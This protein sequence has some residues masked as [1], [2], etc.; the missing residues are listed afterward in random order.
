[1][2]NEEKHETYVTDLAGP[3]D[4]WLSVTDAARIT[5]RQEKTIRDWIE[6]GHLPVH[7][8]RVGLNKRTR[9]VRISDLETLTPIIDPEA[10]ITTDLGLLDLPNIPRAQQHLAEQM[11]TLQQDVG[12]QITA[13]REQ[14]G[15]LTSQHEQFTTDT[16]QVWGVHQDQYRALDHRDAELLRLIQQARQDW[17]AHLQEV[18]RTLGQD[19]ARVLDLHQH[20]DSRVAAQVQDL[21]QAHQDLADLVAQSETRLHQEVTTLASRLAEVEQALRKERVDA[22]RDLERMLT[23]QDARLAREAAS[24]RASLSDLDTRTATAFQAAQEAHQQEHT[25]L[26]ERSLD[27]HRELRQLQETT[28]AQHAD[29]S[30]RLTQLTGTTAAMHTTWQQRAETAE[31]EVRQL[32]RDL[33]SPTPSPPASPK[34]SPKRALFHDHSIRSAKVM[35]SSS[36]PSSAPSSPKTSPKASPTTSPKSS[37][38][39]SP[40]L[41]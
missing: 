26:T 12:E 39:T 32:R 9:Q 13:L 25:V 18:S 14:L 7:P 38:K 22:V 29:T 3:T 28:A 10:G 35:F 6:A 40:M 4:R 36:P 1:M 15:T 19:V 27:T 11:A 41:K 17:T 21:H 31:N 20:L 37:P 24:M 2:A 23:D 33:D 5:R 34:S 8:V 30:T 16:H